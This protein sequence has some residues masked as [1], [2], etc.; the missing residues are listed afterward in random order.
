MPENILPSASADASRSQWK[1]ER[2][3]FGNV[4]VTVD[5]K[6][7]RQ[8]SYRCNGAGYDIPRFYLLRT[9]TLVTSLE[10]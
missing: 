3:S 7:W 1:T 6:G 8:S 2:D 4:E 9:E 10:M 5:Q